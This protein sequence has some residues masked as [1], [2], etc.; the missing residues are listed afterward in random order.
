MPG[1][2]V[3]AAAGDVCHNP[4]QHLSKSGRLWVGPIGVGTD[5][6]VQLALRTAGDAHRWLRG[7]AGRRQQAARDGRVAAE[8]HLQAHPRARCHGINHVRHEAALRQA[9]PAGEGHMAYGG[10]GG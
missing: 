5:Q 9:G 6:R 4:V 7:R 2:D 10:G 1:G 3:A 8:R